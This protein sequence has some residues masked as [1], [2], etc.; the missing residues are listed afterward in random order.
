[1]F[2]IK[3]IVDNFAA[4]CCSHYVVASIAIS[5]NIMTSQC[6]LSHYYWDRY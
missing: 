6:V 1:M 2:A 5:L 4:Y 3:M